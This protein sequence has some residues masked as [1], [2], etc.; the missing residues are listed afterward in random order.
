MVGF[1]FSYIF[2]RLTFWNLNRSKAMQSATCSRDLQCTEKSIKVVHCPPPTQ[3]G[4]NYLWTRYPPATTRMWNLLSIF[5]PPAYTC[6]F[7][8]LVLTVVLLKIYSFLG[9]RLGLD[10]VTE[11]F[12]LIPIGYNNLSNKNLWLYII[13]RFKVNEVVKAPNLFSPG[14]SIQ[15]LKTWHCIFGGILL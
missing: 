4:Y 13:Y 15:L 7:T 1:T 2:S 11:E 3:F 12:I 10:Q 8:S 5:D 14:F 6:F 9:S